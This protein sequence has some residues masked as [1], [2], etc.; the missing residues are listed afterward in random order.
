MNGWTP[1]K[2]NLIYWHHI[3]DGVTAVACRWVGLGIRQVRRRSAIR[4][5]MDDGLYY[6]AWGSSIQQLYRATSK[7]RCLNYLPIVERN[8]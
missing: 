4:H 6:G 7:T 3:F 5:L 8:A 1:Y 2:H